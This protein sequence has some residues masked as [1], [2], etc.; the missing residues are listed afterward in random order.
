MATCMPHFS[1][2]LWKEGHINIVH[3]NGLTI[4]YV[5]NFHVGKR[6]VLTPV[7]ECSWAVV[8]LQRNFLASRFNVS[9]DDHDKCKNFIIVS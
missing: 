5:K 4:N 2:H 9:G 7:N 8:S 3:M 6:K 1:M